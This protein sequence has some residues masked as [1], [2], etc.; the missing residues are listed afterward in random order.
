M[1]GA[2]LLLSQAAAAGQPDIQFHATVDVRSAKVQS[3]GR[4]SVRAWA[5]PDGGSATRSS[6]TSS[7]RHFELHIDARI[8]DPRAAPAAEE[9]A[10][11]QPR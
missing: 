7:S 5:D 6:G 9:T 8:A 4:S 1:L 10:T 11:P 2:L 3:S